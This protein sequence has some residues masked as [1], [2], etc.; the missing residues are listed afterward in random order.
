ME[1]YAVSRLYVKHDSRVVIRARDHA[2]V[3]VDALDDAAVEVH[4]E[5][6]SKVVVN[7][8]AWGHGGGGRGRLREGGT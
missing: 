8:Y 7:L 1:K 3:M 2:F 4:C 6:E 5:G